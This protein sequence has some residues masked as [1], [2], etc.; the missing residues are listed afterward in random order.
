MEEA[1]DQIP[2][3][4]GAPPIEEKKTNPWLIVAIIV[5]VLL[6]CCCLALF[7]V[8]ALIGPATSN[9]FSNIINNIEVTPFP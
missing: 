4:P 9:V 7:M 2:E 8:L 1:M 6:V 3:V 5:V